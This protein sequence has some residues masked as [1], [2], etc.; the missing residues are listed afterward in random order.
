M[1]R[2]LTPKAHFFLNSSFV[3][4][5]RQ[6]RAAGGHPVLDMAPADAAAR[7]LADGAA[8]RIRNAQGVMPA[9]LRVTDAVLAG[10]VA[11]PGK[12]WSE[13]G[14]VANV[15]SPASWSPGGQPAFNDTFV[16]VIAG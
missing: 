8:V 4:Q 16:E 14:A 11:L 2:L 5:P 15:L 10:V 9:R 3:N 7:G 6:N 13:E 12:W 1:L